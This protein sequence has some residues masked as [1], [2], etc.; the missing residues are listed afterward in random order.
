MTLCERWR[1]LQL[2]ALAD[3]DAQNRIVLE[4][5][6]LSPRARQ[7]ATTRRREAENQLRLLRNEDDDSGHSDF[8]TYRYLPGV[9]IPSQATAF[10]GCPWRPTYPPYVVRSG[11]RD[12]GDYIQRPRFLAIAEFGPGYAHITTRVRATEVNRVVP[13]GAVG[14]VGRGHLRGPTLPSLRVSPRP[15]R[16]GWMREP[17]RRTGRHHVRLMQSPTAYTRSPGRGS[18]RTRKNAAARASSCRRP[19]GSASTAPARAN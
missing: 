19:T 8:Y 2:A 9:G 14:T 1:R 3:Q 7:A 17:R 6:L 18:R 12:G 16:V 10:R 15:A 4:S 5:H 13:L 11:P